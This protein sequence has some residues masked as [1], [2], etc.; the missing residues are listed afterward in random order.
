M[1]EITGN[2]FNQGFNA[3]M[4]DFVLPN[5]K[6]RFAHGIRIINHDGANYVVVNI[7]GTEQA[8]QLTAGFIPVGAKEHNEVLYLVSWNDTTKQIE[9][10]SYPSPDYGDA[11]TNNKYR[12]FNNL[13]GG[14]F[15]TASYG[16]AK[17]PTVDVTI[18]DDYDRS[19][20]V[21]FTVKGSLPRIV[22]SKFKI[23]TDS[24][25]NKVYSI[26][27]DRSG[28]ANSNTYANS[29]VEK[30]TRLIISS[31]KILGIDF[32][33]IQSG[34]KL[35]PGNYVY[36]F[37]YMTEDFN[38][39]AV[40]GQSSICQVFFGSDLTTIKGGDETQQTDKR[41][42]LQLSN[43]DTDFKYLKV[44][45]L[46]SAGQEGLQQQYLEF[47][48]PT[49]ISGTDMTFV[50]N[51]FEELAEVSQDT[52]NVDYGNISGADTL[53]QISGYLM[54][55]AIK[56]FS[57]DLAPFRQFAQG[58]VP[59]LAIKQLSVTGVNGYANPTNTYN[60]MGYFGRESYPF[61]IVFILPGGVISPAF[62]I[63]GTIINSSLSGN[64]PNASYAVPPNSQNGIVT[65]PVS[66]HFLPFDASQI[67]TKY[68][69]FITTNSS[70]IANGVTQDTIDFIKNT[71]IGFFIVRGE[72]VPSLLTQG[73]LFPTVKVPTTDNHDT[74]DNIDN[75]YW[76][77]FRTQIDNTTFF[78]FL[79]LFDSLMEAHNQI[80]RG[81][82]DGNGP[83]D[84]RVVDDQNRLLNGYMPAF[85]TDYKTTAFPNGTEI[86][87]SKQNETW[88]RH[89]A[90]VT[91]EALVNEPEFTS[92]LQRDNISLQQLAK[93]NFQVTGEITPLMQTPYYTVTSRV[94]LWYDFLSFTR[95][96][97]S[98]IKT[99]KRLVFVPGETFQTNTDFISKIDATALL[100]TYGPNLL[101][102]TFSQNYNSFFGIEMLEGTPGHLSDA[103]K[104]VDSPVG[105]NYRVQSFQPTLT[106]YSLLAGVTAGIL[107][108]NYNKTIP[109][110]FLVSIYPLGGPQDGADLYPTIDNV[111]YRQVTKRL[112]WSLAVSSV[113]VFG[114]DCYISKVYR[115]FNQSPHRDPLELNSA[116]ERRD[117]IDAGIMASWYQESKYNLALRQPKRFDVSELV[118]RSFFPYESKSDFPLYRKYRYPE[119]LAH[120]KGYAQMLTPKDYFT[121]PLNSP[122]LENEFFSRVYASAKHVPNA[123]RNGFRR[124]TSNFQ[125]YTSSLGR[126]VRIFNQRSKLFIVF[127]NGIGL[128]EVASRIQTGSDV[129]GA[130]FLEAKDILPTSLGFPTQ[131]VGSQQFY[132]MVQTPSAIY[133]YDGLRRKL[134]QFRDTFKV[135]SDDGFSSFLIKNPVPN[136]R[137][138]YD[139]ENGEVVFTSDS[140]TLTYK[141]G[142]EQFTS[143][144]PFK[145]TF[146][147]RRGRDF[148][149]FSGN[150]FHRHNAS[151]WT[152]YGQP[153]DSIV[154]F[155][156]NEKLN[157]TKVLDQIELISNE[158]APTKVE[159]FT[160]NQ[161]TEKLEVLQTSSMNQYVQILDE[162]DPYTGRP[163]IIYR[164]KKYEIKIPLIQIYNGGGP[165]DKWGIKGRMVNKYFIVRL[166][167]RPNMLLQLASVVSSFRFSNA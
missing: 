140:W 131:E 89:W 46:Y 60:Y 158:V 87:Y 95:Y 20:N 12:P 111:T 11:Q 138:G 118:D 122:F 51:G 133:G 4:S 104:A 100:T 94:G 42:V 159:I 26:I 106:N 55:G 153:F 81:D 134:W 45:C 145:P 78:K 6:M 72:R 127:E 35:K 64:T 157:I 63:K 50:H 114:G 151:V 38:T 53:T 23:D 139:F 160:Y 36:V 13:Q 59:Q 119:T 128:G 21:V 5:T 149:S 76:N 91:G 65:F 164:N 27:P 162:I 48:N 84:M 14:P 70:L 125:D 73:M 137:A 110:G 24:S 154:E 25:G 54:L 80:S 97:N 37:E 99:I 22:N 102:H 58:I 40:A 101:F 156:V 33:A 49:T 167:Y 126:I 132:S 136:L 52:I 10:G 129:A 28:T 74:D 112:P 30:E 113:D 82:S 108:N 34:G 67:Q 19:V 47:T 9:V 77:A 17:Q 103:S 150:L 57:Y 147:A 71:T 39:T 43:I 88:A 143:F 148:F 66:N 130:I 32:T 56:E 120:S 93:I 109:A 15:R 68:L 155:V 83:L 41:V 2:T 135:I 86:L 7:S 8:F 92:F 117:N 61:A 163:R 1:S 161:T 62:P 152:V 124:I 75:T 142:L 31:D 29:S 16:L 146:Y 85:I 44:F 116:A 98:I 107:Y 123:F 90:F 144:Q 141:E 105:G 115:K 3:D 69:K 166:T 165:T 121:V 96:T 79:P 18:Q